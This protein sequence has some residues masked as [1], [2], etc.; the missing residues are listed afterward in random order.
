M[1]YV[2]CVERWG[3]NSYYTE[4]VEAYANEDAAKDEADK[5]QGKLSPADTR[6]FVEAID[7]LT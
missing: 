2:I 7:F 3:G 4:L 1:I 5:L 6:Y